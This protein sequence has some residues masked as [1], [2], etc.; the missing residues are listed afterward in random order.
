MHRP[1]YEFVIVFVVGA[2]AAVLSGIA[3]WLVSRP[4][5]SSPAR[6]AFSIAL[7]VDRDVVEFALSPDGTTLVYAAVTPG[8]T[9]DDVAGDA[10]IRLYLRR[11]DSFDAQPLAGTQNA[12]QPFFSPDGTRVGFFA[13][14]VLRW[15]TLDGQL[16]V[17][18]IPVRS[19]T[20]GASWTTDD[21]IVFAT[22]DG[23]GLR[24]VSL[25]SGEVD[26]P[27][28]DDGR[29]ITTLTTPDTTA[30]EISHGWPYVLPDGRSIVFTV[31]RRDRDAR[32]AWLTPESEEYD[33][34]WPVDGGAFYVAPA[35]ESSNGQGALVFVRRG[36]VFA[37]PVDPIL[38]EVTG[39]VQAVTDGV[40]GS[41]AGYTRLGRSTLVAAQTG[42]LAYTTSTRDAART[43]LAW[44]DRLGHSV[45]IDA[46]EARHEAPRVAPD[47]SSIVMAIR[48]GPFSR[49]LWE[50]STG[51][52]TR[53]QLTIG[54]GDNHS[55]VWTQDGRFVTFA[56]NR[57]GPQGLYQLSLSGPLTADTLLAGDARTPASWGR[58]GHTLFFHES[59]LDRQ[60]DVW[61]WDA[62]KNAQ[63][64]RLLIGT[65]ANE[66]APAISPDGRWLAYVSDIKD[67]D[68]VYVTP[69][70]DGAG[71]RVSTAGGAEPV[72]SNDGSELFY[73]RGRDLFVVPL[74]EIVDAATAG[75]EP[76]ASR[77]LFSGSFVS[78]PG[79]NV[80][81]YDVGPDGARFVMLRPSTRTT[82]ISVISGWALDPQ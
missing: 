62:M 53:R 18:I 68:Q 48:Q 79:G 35:G 7:P 12:T 46:I 41:A 3:T 64:P 69:Y 61:A 67:G 36:E 52:G 39:P 27:N 60:R 26:G 77:H 59:S 55:P 37:L 28:R 4:P 34:L 21:R 9:E 38:H 19:R 43:V 30:G 80:A 11:L 22:L 78:D 32:L 76:P 14:G 63:S 73:R 49:D 57:D 81:S 25:S 23:H 20:A 70:P 66:R 44:V 75:D 24:M 16:P 58:D 13:D 82:G 56:S 45:D 2:T 1:P 47:G 33:L 74:S 40:A 8:E 72:W 71:Q 31:G 29:V 54:A 42:R 15:M 50:Y 51:P 17:D 10:R 5:D 6:E 65:S